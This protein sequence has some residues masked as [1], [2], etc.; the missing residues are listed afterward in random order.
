MTDNKVQDYNKLASTINWCSRTLSKNYSKTKTYCIHFL[1]YLFLVLTVFMVGMNLPENMTS[2][3]KRKK[4]NWIR[5]LR[6]FCL[7]T[8]R[9]TCSRLSSRKLTQALVITE[10]WLS[11]ELRKCSRKKILGCLSTVRY[12]F[13]YSFQPKKLF[14][15]GCESFIQTFDYDDDEYIDYIINF[16]K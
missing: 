6:N 3:S 2:S 13:S 1:V 10:K 16:L 12:F 15:V 4:I 5:L 11:T 7:L 8:R 9:K 14:D